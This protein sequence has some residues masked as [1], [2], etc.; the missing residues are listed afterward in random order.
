M[1]IRKRT[2]L[3]SALVAALA[4]TTAAGVL[5]GCSRQAP[6]EKPAAQQDLLA[7]IKARGTITIAM[8][9]TWSP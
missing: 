2:L 8:E 7:R 6:E 9:G 5:T 4:C 1:Q 3:K